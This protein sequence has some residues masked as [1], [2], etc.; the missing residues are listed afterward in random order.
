[1]SAGDPGDARSFV[2]SGTVPEGSEVAIVDPSAGTSCPADHVGEI[3]VRG[4]GVARGYWGQPVASEETFGA[5]LPGAG[6]GPFLRT[7]DLG[8]VREG[9]LFVTGRL[10]D[11][12]I[13]RGRNIYPHDIE[14]T[15]E[16]SHPALRAGGAAAFAVE[17]GGQER[18]AVVIE[19]ERPGKAVKADEIVAAVR[20]AVAEAHEV[21]LYAVRLLKPLSLPKTSSG[22]IQRH[23]CRTAFLDG[24]LDGVGGWTQEV[25]ESPPEARPI[26]SGVDSPASRTSAEVGGW[27]ARRMATRLGVSPAEVDHRV[28]FASFGLGSLQAVALAG[29]LETWLG[30]PL[31][32]TLAYEYP[33]IEALARHL[34]GEDAADSGRESRPAESEPIAVIGIGC[35]FPG[36]RGPSA[37]WQLLASGTDATRAVPEGRWAPIDGVEMGRIDFRR[38]GF[39]DR[40]DL[41][42]ADFFGISPR[43]AVAMDPQQRLL[44]E[45]A[46]EAME[47]AGLAVEGLA[48]SPVGVFVGVSTDD[49]SRLRRREESGDVYDLTGNASSIAANRLS[50]AF[51][52]RGPSVAVDTACSSS[53]VAV[54]WAC[55]SLRAG[56]S[57][58]A[59]A[60]GV[61]L[62]LEPGVSANFARAGFLAADGRC[63]TF[64]AEADGYAR[65]EGAGVVVLKPLSRALADGDP[66]HAVIRGGAINQDGRTNGLTAPSRQAQESVLR[67]AYQA[68]GIEPG[69]A[70][71]VEAHGTGTNLGDPI[72]AHALGSVLAAGRPEGRP[73]LVGSVKTNIGHLEAAA[74]I[75]GLIKV[76]LMLRHRAIPP[77]LHSAAV[78]PQI[79]FETLPIR[80]ARTLDEWP[81]TDGPAFAGISSFG[82]GGTNAHLVLESAPARVEEGAIDGGGDVL[83]PLSA[84]SPEAL[85]E[86]ARA[87]R[88]DLLAGAVDLRDVAYTA[89]RRRDHHDHRLAIVAPSAASAAEALDAFLRGESDPRL[90]SGRRP[91]GRRPRLAFVFSG[92]G[93]MSWGAGR[94][95]LDREPIFRAVFEECDRWLVAN[96]GRSLLGELADGSSALLADPEVAQTHQFALQVALAALYRSW[97]IEAEAVVGHSLGEIAAAQV[98]GVIG[99]H[100]ALRIVSLRGRLM[101]KAVGHGK[102]AA[103]GI[104]IDDARRRIAGRGEDLAIAAINGPSMTTV[105]GESGAIEELVRSI[106]EEGRFARLLD[107]DCAF[108]GPQMDPLLPEM[109]VGLAG[110]EP[111]AGSIPFVST[112]FGCK[113][114]SH[115]LGASYWVRNLRDTVLFSAAIESLGE[116]SFESILEIGPHPI[117]RGAI[118]ESLQ[119][120]GMGAT[121][122]PSLRRDGPGRGSLLRSLGML[123][124]HGGA[125]AW[126]RLHTAGRHVHFP[127]YPWQ[128]KRYWI[129]EEAEAPAEG[130]P[131][132]R[133]ALNGHAS[134]NGHGSAS[135]GRNGVHPHGRDAGRRRPGPRSSPLRTPVAARGV[136]RSLGRPEGRWA[137]VADG[138]GSGRPS[139]RTPG[140]A[141]PRATSYRSRSTMQEAPGTPRS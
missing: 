121:I 24:E 88:D 56:E 29:E 17:V 59:L 9:E 84:R 113:V 36:A 101:R 96:A 10:K 100:D 50:Y 61:N 136:I 105:S 68:S 31:S 55:R 130:H 37:F 5:I 16:R 87:V 76:A 46:W 128:G 95:I 79:P 90:V 13:I 45:V 44:L 86:L 11:L 103:V 135:T 64:S 30:R 39:L 62:L 28:T 74:G 57:S 65:G 141:G 6:D 4:S 66:I 60:G 32:P 47:D 72:E 108:H 71:Y 70:D 123:Y 63:K 132:P 80:V 22:K 126:D 18:L 58:I 34:A 38:G 122:V 140:R 23:A 106:R 98:A 3:W 33:T 19:V 127:S 91:P 53:L 73:C 85:R 81:A 69:R 40:V 25:G 26:V 42:D 138:A 93:G 133:F 102:T 111:R 49:Y 129:E 97:G 137:A 51:D 21:D 48:G 1:M 131:T 41:F 112:V 15:A 115:Q 118:A 114:D 107:V 117:H 119:A 54:E 120:R 94:D 77:S 116:D 52:F 109:E 27:L 8:F 12:I 89:A 75:A 134:T 92:Q 35:R 139:G 125:I 7:G 14:W 82:F 67:A 20:R 43:E 83:L 78:N 104:S 124:A 99:L 2:S 110:L